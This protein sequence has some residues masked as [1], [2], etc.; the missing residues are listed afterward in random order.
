ML[1]EMIIQSFWRMSSVQMKIVEA[2]TMAHTVS[3][4]GI[5][6]RH[7]SIMEVVIWRAPMNSD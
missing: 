6:L 1:D 2:I 4:C 7:S 5:I 3:E